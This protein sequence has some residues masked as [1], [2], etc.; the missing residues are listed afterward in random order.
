MLRTLASELW[1]EYRLGALPRLAKSVAGARIV[2]FPLRRVPQL[3][4]HER[5][6]S[7]W[8]YF[9]PTAQ[10]A[11]VFRFVNNDRG[12]DF[13]RDK[14]LSFERC[15]ERGVP[16]LP[17]SAV[18]LRRLDGIVRLPALDDE[19][20][21]RR[22][23]A[24]A[25]MP[26]DAFIKPAGGLGGAGAF[27]ARRANGHWRDGGKQLDLDGL[28]GRI[29]AVADD[30]GVII[31]PRAVPHGAMS[32]AGARFGLPTLRVQTALTEDG[33]EVVY[34][35]QKILGGKMLVDNFSRG[36]KGNLIAAVDPA[37]GVY[38][39]AKGL[40]AGRKAVLSAFSHHPA[41]GEPITGVTLPMIADIVAVARQT[42]EAFPESPLIGSDIAVT[43]DGVR[44]VEVNNSPD[45]LLGQ[46]ATGRGVGEIFRDVLPR[47]SMP[48][49]DRA[50]AMRM[51][52]A[53]I[54]KRWR[55][56]RFD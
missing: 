52:A 54:N 1:D 49:A 17:L 42:A 22:F 41:T 39:Q 50:E 14:V 40:A 29:A 18:A 38:G 20:A 31:Q 13:F 4:L 12:G 5:P 8:P 46:I 27:A 35:V 24:G 43:T 56:V 9:A 47:L 28:V 45:Q 6:L 34:V 55:R 36:T 10:L 2:G 21:L 30:K 19:E 15:L 51:F 16:I 37:T 53:R 25:A 7:Q 44:I 33:P 3:R 32:L 23:V 26:D 11:S 48:A